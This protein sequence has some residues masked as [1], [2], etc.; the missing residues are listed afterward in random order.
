MIFVWIVNVIFFTWRWVRLP[1]CYFGGSVLMPY[2]S[3][4]SFSCSSFFFV[5]I[6]WKACVGRKKITFYYNQNYL[7]QAVSSHLQW[8]KIKA[9]IYQNSI[10]QSN[11]DKKKQHCWYVLCLR[12]SRAPLGSD[13]RRWNL[14]DGRKRSWRQICPRRPRRLFLLFQGCFLWGTE[15]NTTHSKWL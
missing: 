15:K 5:S 2:F 7:I 1:P 3:F 11:H 4:R 13:C 8:Q 6:F 9:I 12:C 10:F 14:T